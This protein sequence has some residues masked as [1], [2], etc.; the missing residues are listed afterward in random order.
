MG[1]GSLILLEDESHINMVLAWEK[2]VVFCRLNAIAISCQP[3]YH[4]M[5]GCTIFTLW[6]IIPSPLIRA[7]VVVAIPDHLV[8]ATN[9]IHSIGKPSLCQHIGTTPDIVRPPLHRWEVISSVAVAKATV[10]R[11]NRTTVGRKLAKFLKIIK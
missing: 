3:G 10:F 8:D 11:K 2:P 4:L 1:D 5:L 7:P 6:A 9:F